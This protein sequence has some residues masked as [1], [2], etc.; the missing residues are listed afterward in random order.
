MTRTRSIPAF[1]IPGLQTV[2]PQERTGY[3]AEREAFE[4]LAAARRPARRWRWF[5]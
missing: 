1:M 2:E 3:R 4:A 5:G